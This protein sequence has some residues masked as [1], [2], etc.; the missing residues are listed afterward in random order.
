MLNLSV[1]NEKYLFTVFILLLW[2]GCRK[3]DPEA[4]S[5][6]YLFPQEIKDYTFFMPGTYWVYQDSISGVEDCVYVINYTAGID[7]IDINSNNT[8]KEV[9]EYFGYETARTYDN[10]T[11]YYS[12]NTSFS[13]QCV[14]NNEKRPCFWTNREK[15]GPGNYV[16]GGFCFLYKFYDGAWS[17]SGWASGY[18]KVSIVSHWNSII[19]NSILYNSVV[20][21][22]DNKN[23]TENDNQTNLFFARNIGIIRKELLDSN[24]TWNLIRFNIVQ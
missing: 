8:G 19:L 15:W 11:Y 3:K 20:E 7:T 2:Q 9:V 5:G 16:G 24:E 1:C 13:D 21:F 6:V 22:N 17:Y 23:I 12:S 10:F 18:S 4:I 14:D